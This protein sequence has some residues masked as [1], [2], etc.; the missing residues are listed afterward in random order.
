MLVSGIDP[1]SMVVSCVISGLSNAICISAG[2]TFHGFIFR[3]HYCYNRDEMVRNALVSMYCKFGLISYAENIFFNGGVSNSI[4]DKEV[5]NAMVCG[6]GKAK[7]GAKCID[8]FRE[9]VRLGIDPDSYGLVSVICSCS[10]LGEMHLGRSLHGYAVKR[11][12]MNEHT[13]VSNSLIDMYGSFGEV[14]IARKLFCRTNKDDVVTWNTMISAYA[15][16]GR[17]AEAFSLFDKMVLQGNIKPT[18]TTLVTVLSACA[19]MAS[20]EKGEEV[21]HKYIDDEMLSSNPTV[22]TALVDMYAKCGQLEKSKNVF[23]KMTERDVVSWNVMISGYG[24]HGDA[25]SAIDTFE[26]MERSNAKPNELTFLAL[27]SA[28]S[29]VGL[30]EEGKSLFGR[31]GDY[32]LKPTLKHYACMVGSSGRGRKFGFVN[33]DGSDGGLWGALLSA[34]K[35]HNDPKMGIRIAR[36]AIECDPQNDGYYVTISNLYDAIGMWEEADRART[37]MKERGVEKAVGW[38]AVIEL[39]GKAAR[40]IEKSRIVPRH[41][42]QLAVADVTIANGR[43]YAQHPQPFASEEGWWFVKAISVDDD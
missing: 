31:M 39:A 3:R 40:D 2:K 12:M 38:S 1:D 37:L 16:C 8:L 42:L 33:A 17:Y 27:L 13:S 5:W 15:R 30:V 36:R 14:G 20:I 19:H 43:C 26:Q 18:T 24:M 28:C 7:R 23:N 29:H 34:C 35:T 22:A 4:I 32:A 41:I 21:H 25:R 6:Y 9:M 11:L 10:Q